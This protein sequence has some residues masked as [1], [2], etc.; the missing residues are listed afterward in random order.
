MTYKTVLAAAV[1]AVVTVPVLAQRGPAPEPTRIA[2]EVIALACSPRLAFEVPPHPLRITGGQDSA[3]RWTFAP[4]D[5]ITVN[6]GTD[7]GI[8]VGQLYYV[9]RVQPAM[10]G[11]VSRDNPATIRTAGWIRIYAVDKA[12]SLAT[13]S[14]A[15]D[16]IEVNDFLE[17][18][19][20]P[21]LT[22]PASTSV[23]P[24]KSNYGHVLLGNDGRRNFGRG[25]FM[26]IDRGSDHGITKGA[27]FVV[28]RDKDQPENFLFELG[29]AVVV[30][31]RSETS[32]VLVTLARDSIREGDYV[33]LRR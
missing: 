7:N 5:L 32:T 17:P 13:V 15:C 30:D 1:A 22:T 12:M 26:V 6:A 20:L 24:Q 21:Q 8:D 19:A 33:A 9:R 25:D 18:F 2:P 3:A 14:H 31:V 23:P 10:R 11:D 16:S 27:Q 4:G 29:E 28:Y